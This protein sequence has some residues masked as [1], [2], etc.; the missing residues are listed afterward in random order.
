[1]VLNGQDRQAYRYIRRLHSYCQ[2]HGVSRETVRFEVGSGTTTAIYLCPPKWCGAIVLVCHSLGADRYYP[3][4]EIFIDMLQDNLGVFS[5]DLDGHGS[6]N[7]HCF[8]FPEVLSTIPMTID[9]L[10]RRYGAQP[11]QIVLFGHSLGG[12][13]CLRA[14]ASEE[15]RG[16]IAVSSPWRIELGIRAA[17]ELLAVLNP[18]VWR[19]L[20]YYSLWELVPAFRGFKRNEFP[21]RT[22]HGIG[23]YLEDV[24]AV[25]EQMSVQHAVSSA[26][27]PLLQ[28]H[29][30]LDQVV[31]F[32]QAVE[33][34]QNYRG[35]K[36]LVFLA[37]DTHMSTLFSHTCRLSIRRW[38]NSQ[39]SLS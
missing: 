34:H 39:F 1:V 31:P 9:F 8:S 5:I 18:G 27:A 21:C 11:S 19:Q 23:S 25:L 26:H 13:I 35:A 33:I 3:F 7:N 29:G 2:T 38:L 15:C 10:R 32:S 4:T 12:T 17:G 37:W 22:V 6:G 20:R 28:I 24:N 16:V 14:A 30:K 36:E